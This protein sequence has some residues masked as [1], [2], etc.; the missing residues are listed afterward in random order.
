MG[1]RTELGNDGSCAGFFFLLGRIFFIDIAA[2]TSLVQASGFVP[3]WFRGGASLEVS[4]AGGKQGLDCVSTIFDGVLCKSQGLVVI[5]ISFSD[6]LVISL[7][8]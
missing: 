8:V 6:L 2:L 1:G 5:S 7:T 4:I 3:A